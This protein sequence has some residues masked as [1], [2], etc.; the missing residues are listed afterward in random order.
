MR[1]RLLSTFLLAVRL[2]VSAACAA[3]G[4]LAFSA[5]GMV[6]DKREIVLAGTEN[7][8]PAQ[9]ILSEAF[10][11]AG[12]GVKILNMPWARCL[13]EARNGGIDGIYGATPTPERE[14]ELLFTDEA[15]WAEIQS[16]F[17]RADDP[18]DYQPNPAGLADV[19]VGLMNASATGSEF[20]KAVA[21][22]R[23]RHVDYAINF[24][25]LLLMLTGQRVE[26]A[27]ADRRSVIGVAKQHG[28]LDKIRELQPPVLEDP[29]YIA[30]TRTRDLSAVSREVG[31]A[32]REMKQD[33]SYA[34]LFAQHFK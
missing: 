4:G 34:E 11:R 6:A 14:S 5:A 13:T 1:G 23:L 10:R 12:Y 29:V 3:E 21:E 2:A 28:M 25:S 22:K 8:M 31:A 16:A 20:D 32:L 30:F 27:I 26:V 15:L 17:A 33:G 7:G 19:R 9:E 24:D 18:T